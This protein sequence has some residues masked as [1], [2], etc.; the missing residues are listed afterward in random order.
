VNIPRKPVP[1][2]PPVMFDPPEHRGYR[3]IVNPVF[4][5]AKVAEYEPW[6][7]QTANR[8]LDRVL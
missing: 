3:E 7:R 5:P 1:D 2:L 8:Y 4:T 6:I